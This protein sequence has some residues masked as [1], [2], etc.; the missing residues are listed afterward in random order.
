MSTPKDVNW[1][2]TELTRA[3]HAAAPRII[4]ENILK[5]VK[6]EAQDAIEQGLSRRDLVLSEVI[7]QSYLIFMSVQPAS[8]Y[9]RLHL[10]RPPNQ[11]SHKE[12]NCAQPCSPQTDYFLEIYIWIERDAGCEAVDLTGLVQPRGW[13]SWQRSGG[14]SAG[15]NR[16]IRRAIPGWGLFFNPHPT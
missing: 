11:M 15:R 3:R 10:D 12:A 9:A 7:E 5:V 2:C 4:L 6:Q 8:F 1:L 14:G 16:I 13:R